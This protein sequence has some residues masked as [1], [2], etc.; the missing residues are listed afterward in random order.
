MAK[1]RSTGAGKTPGLPL[2]PVNGS[3]RAGGPTQIDSMGGMNT[4]SNVAG[5]N[6]VHVGGN[7]PGS[8]YPNMMK[9][10]SK[11]S[12]SSKPNAMKGGSKPTGSSIAAG[13]IAKFH[14]TRGASKL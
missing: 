7:Q 4:G 6:M 10:G 11:P 1:N 14:A 2:G 12:G 9:G 13:K 5:V 3:T 8:T